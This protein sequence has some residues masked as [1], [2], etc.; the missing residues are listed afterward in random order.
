MRL[1]V[2]RIV[3]FG[4]LPLLASLAPLL[5]LGIVT[6]SCTVQE[7]AALG[8]GQAVGSFATA[9]TLFGWQVVG[10]PA[11]ALAADDAQRRQ[12]YLTSWWVRIVVFATV[13]P[14]AAAVAAAVTM[15][16][17]TPAA[18]VLAAVMCV[19]ASLSGMS[20][21]WYAI[22]LG[23][24]RMITV[25]E[26]IPRLCALAVGAGLVWATAEALW[27]PCAAIVGVAVTQTMFHRRVF[28]W[29]APP[30]PGRAAV[31]AAG[32]RSAPGAGVTMIAGVRSAAPT[33]LAPS[34][35]TAAAVADLSSADRLY[36]YALFSASALGDALQNWV[37]ES[38]RR[39]RQAAAL[40]LHLTLGTVGAVGLVL[41]GPW[42]SGVLFG[43]RLAGSRETF[44]GFALA[45]FF[46]CVGTPLVR[47][48]LVPLGRTRRVVVCDLVGLACGAIVGAPLVAGL[49]VPGI[50]M[51]LAVVEG[52]AVLGYAISVVAARRSVSSD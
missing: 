43:E 46:V 17:A 28:G 26:V 41:L 5:L 11:I 23:R 8:I 42:A 3:G 18:T 13:T 40:A 24:A 49:Q 45:F 38:G 20:M 35:G 29:F 2:A 14:P 30:W 32:R 33:A 44:I 15:P 22:G 7:W 16:L 37:L 50:P 25:F 51:A 6:R 10:P 52:V 47:N 1:L 21:T 27:Y 4:S 34:I 39:R 9:A 48:V 31:W 36:R 12:V 19:A